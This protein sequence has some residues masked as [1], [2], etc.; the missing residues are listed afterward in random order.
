MALSRTAKTILLASGRFATNVSTIVIFAALARLLAVEEYAAYR[1]VLL[2]HTTA[3][4]LLSLGLPQALYYFMPL[5][6]DRAR[7][8]LLENLLLLF[9][10]GLLFLLAMLLGLNRWLADLVGNPQIGS[11][12]LIIAVYPAVMMPALSL[13]ACLVTRERVTRIPLFNVVTRGLM[14]VLVVGAAAYH[15]SHQAAIVALVLNALIILGPALK[16]MW[17]ACSGTRAELTRAG[18]WRQLAYSVPL[19]ASGIVGILSVSLNQI[20]VSSI[21]SAEEFAIYINGA[22]EI[23]IVRILMTSI[24]SVLLPE[25]VELFKQGRLDRIIDIWRKSAVQ[26]AV[27]LVPIMVFG[28]FLADEL[29]RFIF[30]AKFEA[31]AVPFRLLLLLL[32]MRSVSVN[33]VFLATDRS[34]LV[35][36]RGAVSLVL[37]VGLSLLAVRLFGYLGAATALVLVMYLWVIPFTLFANA[38]ILQTSV[39][40]IYP[41]SAVLRVLVVAVAVSPI[42]LLRSVLGGISDWI[43]LAILALAYFPA[44]WIGLRLIRLPDLPDVVSILRGRGFTQ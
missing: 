42:L 13:P 26:A 4:P 33:V 37:N 39:R 9:G 30:S 10:I 7:G 12:L 31:A 28:L 36:L 3:L 32:L 29:I 19:G 40:R 2:V 5:Q 6:R 25:F 15:H 44:F 34:R 20:V 24:N 8:V 18:M 35:L 38:R 1:Q 11:S 16:L 27:I 14:V 17:D 23:P 21:C 22:V 43:V 41:W